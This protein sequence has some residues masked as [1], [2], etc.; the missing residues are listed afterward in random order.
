[1]N[2][3]SLAWWIWLAIV[4]ALGYGLFV[5]PIGFLIAI[6]LQVLN[7]QTYVFIDKSFISFSVQVRLAVLGIFLTGQI[8]GA[9]WIYW[10]PFVGISVREITGY[11]FMARVL[12]LLPWNRKEAF[13]MDL[14]KRKFLTPPTRGSIL[15][16]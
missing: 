16:V 15:E 5:D 12:S 2:L 1:M 3:M 8:P 10:I 14:L 9:S 4:S 6:I 11:C 13:S 7:L